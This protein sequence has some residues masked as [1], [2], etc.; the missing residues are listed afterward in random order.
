LAAFAFG[1][2][3]R[4]VAQ[5]GAL[6]YRM[7]RT[8]WRGIRFKQD[9]TAWEYG[10][11]Y[12]MALA[13]KV[14]SL[15]LAAPALS[16]W[17]ERARIENLTFGSERFAFD[18]RAR[19][20]YGSFLL[21]WIS[22]PILV[23]AVFTLFNATI[24]IL[25]LSD[26]MNFGTSWK[27]TVDGQVM[28]SASTKSGFDK[29]LSA[30]V[31]VPVSLIATVLSAIAIWRYR[32]RWLRY[33]TEHTSVQGVRFELPVTTVGVAWL[34]IG[35]LLI[36]LFSLGLLSVLAGHRTVRFWTDNA[37]VIGA[38]DESAIAQAT[39]G[40]EGAEGVGSVIGLDALAT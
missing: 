23:V 16:M 1:L 15:G 14:F 5:Y 37:R 35:N 2:F 40:G 32:A 28:G 30:M 10:L 7:G 36:R 3:I 31:I 11:M 9:R 27:F 38:I 39:R 6:R 4:G 18:G 24:S 33:V 25:G 17:L 29:T 19:D 22:A 21:A 34:E 8:T 12:V 26:Q 13:G 20:I